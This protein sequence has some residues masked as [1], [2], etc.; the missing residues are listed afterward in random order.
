MGVTLPHSFYQRDTVTVAREL[1][2]KKL[3]RIYR[4]R[5]LSGIIVETEAY[6]GEH[7]RAAHT[8]G[9]RRTLRN[10]AMYKEGGHAYVYF[11]YGMHFCI[12][13]V[14]KKKNEPEAVLLRA[15]ECVEGL[16]TIRKLR[17]V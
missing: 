10:E 11:V 13:A 12:N 14:T 7:D 1:L 17:K 2:G 9:L 16:D 8:F 4:G 3:V 6:L 15:I 5:R